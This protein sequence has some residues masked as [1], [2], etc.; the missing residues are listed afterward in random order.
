[1]NFT[2]YRLRKKTIE[3]DSEVVVPRLQGTVDEIK[4]QEIPD[5]FIFMIRWHGNNKNIR[6]PIE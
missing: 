3:Q 1:M 4:K 2:L 6:R 5:L